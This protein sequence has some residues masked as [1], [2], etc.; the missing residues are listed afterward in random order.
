MCQSISLNGIWRFVPDLDPQYHSGPEY[1]QTGWDRR[2]WDVVRVPGCWNLY[3]ERYALFEGVAW[4][5]HSFTLADWTPTQ[6]GTLRFGA[7]NYEAQVYL[8]G[9]P[10]GEHRGGYT[11]FTLDVSHLLQPG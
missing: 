4:F 2:H 3:G 11:E 1:A 5:A 10:V 7:V 9:Q 6:I 8:N